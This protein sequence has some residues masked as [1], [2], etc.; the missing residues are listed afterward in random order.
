[1]KKSS[2]FTVKIALIYK[3]AP[4][5]GVVYAPALDICYWAKQNEGAFKDRKKIP[6]KTEN[7]LNI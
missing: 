1:V 5:L 3:D 2:E 7:Q 6:L 4:V